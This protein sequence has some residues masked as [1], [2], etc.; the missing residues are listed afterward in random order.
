MPTSA[1]SSGQAVA[2][3]AERV[4]GSRG[5]VAGGSEA[6]AFLK[7]IDGILPLLRKQAPEAEELRR[8]PDESIRA[9]TDADVFRAV[10]PRQWGGLEID[11]STWFE[12]VVRIGSACGSSGWIA[13]LVG[14]HAW[15]IAMFPQEAQ[16]EVWGENP[17]VRIATSFAPTGKAERDKDGFHLTGRWRFVSGVDHSE[18]IVLAAVLPDDG[19]GRE[20]RN[21]LVPA[22]DFEIDQDSWFVE[23]LQ[24][25][26]SKDVTVDSL[27]PD[28]RTQTIEQVYTATEPGRT[29]NPGPLF[30]LPWLSMFAYAVGA[31]AIGAAV[32]ALEEFVEDNRDRVSALMG[33]AAVQN[34]PVH[35][36]LAEAAT[37]VKDARARI[38]RTWRG[39]YSKALAGEQISDASRAQ[40]RYEGSYAVAGCLSA[41]MKVFEIA[42]GG[43]LHS[44]KPF[45]RHLRDLMAMRNHPFCVP[46][47]W[48]SLYS[49]TLFGLPLQPPLDRSSLGC[50][51]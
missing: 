31:A 24:G 17:D 33:F 23:G 26:G 47:N 36:R 5:P 51:F 27:V 50:L 14:G 32:G 46:E 3:S 49:T 6:A 10:Q 41:V 1:Q 37:L 22:R 30:Q 34:P 13:G 12:A 38:P 48:A 7:R 44:D 20:W 28:H 9:M 18:W 4:A 21:F 16:Q 11:P 35:V 45:Q 43:V 15:H 19:E 29:A 25:T 39:F 40:C 8:M 2:A 42:G